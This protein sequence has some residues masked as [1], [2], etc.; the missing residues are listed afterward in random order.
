MYHWLAVAIA[1]AGMGAKPAPL[2]PS[3]K[4]IVDYQEN[5]CV[6]S[7][8]FGPPSE[9]IKMGF[10]PSMATDGGRL[11]F[12]VPAKGDRQPERGMAAISLQP[13]GKKLT[14]DYTAGPIGDRWAILTWVGLKEM[15]DFTAATTIS[16]YVN[17][18]PPITLQTG[19]LTTTRKA[20]QA[21]QDD[22]AKEWGVDP[23]NRIS[24]AE[25]PDATSWFTYKDYP[26]SAL[27]QKTQ[28][29]AVTLLTIR[30]D[31]YVDACRIV[32]SSG[33]EALDQKTCE[34]AMNKVRFGK[35]QRDPK[36]PLRWTLL[37]VQW[38]L[39]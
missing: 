28:G 33:V 18:D 21:C 37:P 1:L 13:S 8:S 2:A 25:R 17:E 29:R 11:V 26:K 15:E 3:S 10:E 22:L 5:A 4:W 31:G 23:A 24:D 34:V 36:A 7:R 6:L 35:A 27:K 19:G 32:T 12:V 20:V 9:S 38:R 14:S 16:V 30:D 39:G